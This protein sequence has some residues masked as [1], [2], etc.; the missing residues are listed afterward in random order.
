MQSFTIGDAWSEC[1][2][3]FQRNTISLLVLVGGATFVG[4]IIAVFAFGANDASMQS[5]MMQMQNNPTV[6]MRA[7]GPMIAGLV[8]ASYLQA[9][10][11]V[12]ALRVGLSSEKEP[13]PAVVYGLGAVAALLLFYL[14][15][16]LVIGLP[17]GLLLGVIG[18]AGM[19]LGGGAG[20]AGAGM[21]VALAILLF[22]PLVLWISARLSVMVPIMAAQRSFNPFEA[23]K[24]SWRLTAAAQW[25]LIG[26]ILLFSLGM[27]VIAMVMG[28]FS[29]LFTAVGGVNFGA[30]ISGTLTGTFSQIASV[31]MSA[32]IFRALTP[33]NPGDVFA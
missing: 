14:V 7:A 3:F 15:L 20:A 19:A 22:V 32:G 16:G 27:V 8:I 1:F 13:T 6:A 30:L 18:A 28:M 12:A 10:G 4:Q 24:T 11:G 23:A 26:F 25:T 2:D 21:G 17:L 29:L 33:H 5:A 31:V 9:V